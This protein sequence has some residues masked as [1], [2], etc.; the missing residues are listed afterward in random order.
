MNYLPRC[1]RKGPHRAFYEKGKRK[2]PGYTVRKMDGGF[3]V[4]DSRGNLDTGPMPRNRARDFARGLNSEAESATEPPAGL[5]ESEAP[6]AE[7]PTVTT[8]YGP[9][10]KDNFSHLARTAPDEQA[11]AYWQAKADA[12]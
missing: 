10:A 3:G 12:L 8:H 11:R 2:M 7:L 9:M 1:Q 4:F 6:K 5:A